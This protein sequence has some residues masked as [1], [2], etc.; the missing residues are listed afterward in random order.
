[1]GSG[2][3][4]VTVGPIVAAIV[5]AVVTAFVF[6]RALV[7]EQ[8]TAVTSLP[9]LVEALICNWG[10]I[11]PFANVLE[12]PARIEVRAER[13]RRPREAAMALPRFGRGNP[14]V[15]AFGDRII[16]RVARTAIQVTDPAER[17]AS[18]MLR[19]AERL[20][21]MDR[22]SGGFQIQPGVGS[23]ENYLD[24]GNMSGASADGRLSGDPLASDLS[25]APSFG[26]LPI[27]PNEA[28]LLKV[29]EG[30]S[31]R[32]VE[33]M[34]DVSP[35]DFNIREDFPVEALAAL[36]AFATGHGASM[37]TITCADAETHESTI[38]KSTISAARVCMA[39]PVSS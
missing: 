6:I 8:S 13:F 33:A 27:N 32:G 23:F 9:E 5:S 10:W 39:G 1:M 16:G 30:Y 26:D 3:W 22:P 34:W 37:M 7:F 12:G 15:D 31:R 35:T 25:P 28:S 19:V 2:S 38:T 36:A 11:E 24:W 4:I 20:G 18:K 17:T 14:E 21:T 29:M